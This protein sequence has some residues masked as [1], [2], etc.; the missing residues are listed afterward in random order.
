MK[1]ASITVEEQPILNMEDRQMVLM[2]KLVQAMNQQSAALAQLAQA[3]DTQAY[4]ME[5]LAEASHIQAKAVERLAN[6]F[7]TIGSVAHNI[8]DAIV[9]IDMSMKR[10]YGTTPT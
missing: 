6:S 4:A 2:E 7:E 9:N 5:R 10:C 8:R 1:E 3:S